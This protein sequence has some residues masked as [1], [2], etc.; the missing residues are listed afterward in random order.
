MS[1]TMQSNETLSPDPACSLALFLRSLMADGRAVVWTEQPSE[2][3]DQDLVELLAEWNARA[4]VD[5]ASDPPEF[6]SPAALW[7]TRLF[8]QICQLVMFRDL[9]GE[10]VTAVFATPCPELRGP[11]TDWS[12]DLLLRHLPGLFQL[13]R[14]LSNADPLL[15]ELRGLASAWPLSSVGVPDLTDLQIDTFITHPALRRLYADRIIAAAD[16]TRLGDPRLDDVLRADLGIHRD[17]APGLVGKLFDSG[18]IDVSEG[19]NQAAQDS[20]I[21]IQG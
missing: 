9:G 10:K 1:G 19:Q 13:A 17:L 7:A 15:N 18:P 4:A 2:G 14:H 21:G 3:T 12:V 8:Y 5:L 11:R 16:G 6:S 20:R